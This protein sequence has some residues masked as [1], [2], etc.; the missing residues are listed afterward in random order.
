MDCSKVE[1]VE[2]RGVNFSSDKSD[3]G[4]NGRLILADALKVVS[5]RDPSEA[6]TIFGWTDWTGSDAYNAALSQRRADAVKAYFVENGVS[7][8]R[9]TAKGMGK[10]FKYTNRTGDGRWMNRR[11]EIIFSDG[12]RSSDATE[13]TAE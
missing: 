10:S 2:V 8:D 9:I 1:S 6:I 7:P 13:R 11:V 12:L 5:S 4:R 3:I